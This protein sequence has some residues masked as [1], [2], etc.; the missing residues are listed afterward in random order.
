MSAD[1]DKNRNN[2]VLG[3]LNEARGAIDCNDKAAAL[4]AIDKAI[5]RCQFIRA[6]I[7]AELDKL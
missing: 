3:W 4:E 1:H 2:P 5:E 6:T 7:V